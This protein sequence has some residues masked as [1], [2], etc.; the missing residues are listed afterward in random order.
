[1]EPT[2]RKMT[3]KGSMADRRAIE[4]VVDYSG[5]GVPMHTT[6]VTFQGSSGVDSPGPVLMIASSGI[7]T[8]VDEPSRFG[9]TFGPKWVER[10]FEAAG[11]DS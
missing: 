9:D 8:F 1:M 2:I 5:S 11:E 10:F 3:D 7:Q 4:A 6:V